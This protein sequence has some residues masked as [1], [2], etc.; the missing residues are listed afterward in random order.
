MKHLII[1]TA[2]HIDHGKTSLIKMLTDIDCDTHKEEKA[3]GITINLGFAHI[4]LPSGE[5]AGIIDVPGHKDFINTMVGGACGIDMVLLVI[6]ADSGI[7]PQT[8]EH[9][10]II[11]S[12]GIKKGVV[13]LT[14]TDL[15]DDELIEIAKSEISDFLKN[16][17]LKDAPIIGVSALTSAGKNELIA[18]IENIISEIQTQE[19]GNLFRMYIDRIFTVKGF[20]CVVTGSVLGGSVKIGDD[21]FLLPDAKQKLRI[22]TIEKHGKKVDYVEKGDRAA[23]NLIGLK[24]EDFE[25]GM[26]ISDKQLQTTSMVDAY[27]QLFDKIPEIDLW[28]KVIF[29]S[30]TFE[31]QAKMHLLNKDSISSGEDAIVQLHFEKPAIL[32]NKDKFII[33]NSSADIT[34]GG[35]NIIDAVPLHHRKRTPELIENLTGICVNI[36]SENT[37]NENIKLILNKEFK[38]FTCEEIAEKLNLNLDE[39]K[40]NIDFKSDSYDVLKSKDSDILISVKCQ[41]IFETKILNAI[42]DFHENNSLKAD[43]LE[44]N[45]LTGKLGLNKNKCGKIFLE[46]MLNKI[47]EKGLIENYKNTWILKGHT[48][49]LDS[50]SE[51]E[52]LWL[53]K[54]I[55]SYNDNKPALSEIEEKAQ[56]QKIPK[57]KIKPYLSYLA[58]KQKIRFSNNDFIHTEI[59]NKN[60]KIL[61]ETLSKKQEGITIAEYKD[62]IAGTKTFRALIGEIYENEKFIQY[63]HGDNIETKIIITQKGKDYLNANIS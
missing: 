58:D 5:S 33:R 8:I 40:S 49:K 22:R 54:I 35:G 37:V 38:P 43:G 55:L 59:L 10:N 17:T 2:G 12:L 57:N 21:V 14:K 29:I 18:E 51:S 9:T 20:G 32:L 31:T 50:K 41:N 1:G 63:V 13:A 27:I 16:T 45:D 42:K 30:G 11:S 34:L 23:L 6:A 39:L 7:M 3:R 36:L 61:L 60:R 26:L 56:I 52:I 25:R 19:K 28:S 44:I 46:L 15:V 24:T 48:A 47:K 4:Q 62:I 53:E